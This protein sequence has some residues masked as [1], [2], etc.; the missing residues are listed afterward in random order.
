MIRDIFTV[1]LLLTATFYFMAGVIQAPDDQEWLVKILGGGFGVAANMLWMI[2][3]K[4]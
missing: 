2:Y 4:K 3:D 1:F